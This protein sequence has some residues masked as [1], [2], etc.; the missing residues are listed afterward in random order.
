[1]LLG[2]WVSI[3]SEEF[4]MSVGEQEY[5]KKFG[6]TL[7]LAEIVKMEVFIVFFL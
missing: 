6:G 7:W 2:N 1:V 4:G 3:L 5:R